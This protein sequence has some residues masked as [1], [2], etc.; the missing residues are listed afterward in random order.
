MNHLFSWISYTDNFDWDIMP[1]A[2]LASKYCAV[3][4]MYPYNAH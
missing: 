2:G 4:E 3:V 1:L